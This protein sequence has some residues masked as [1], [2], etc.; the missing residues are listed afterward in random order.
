M[1]TTHFSASTRR[2]CG[3]TDNAFFHY[4]SSK[5]RQD[6]ERYARYSLCSDCSRLLR[7]A[8]ASAPAE[9]HAAD[10]GLPDLWGGSAK[11]QAWADR[12]RRSRQQLVSG[13]RIRAAAT[14]EPLLELARLTLD[15]MFRIQDPGF[16]IASEKAGFH[17]DSLKVDV[18]LLLK[19]RLSPLDRTMAGSVIGYWLQA[20]W[21]AVS[22]IARDVSDRIKPRMAGDQAE[23]TA[24]FMQTA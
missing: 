6:E 1:T 16:W 4:H 3:H 13:F 12:I 17:V 20:D 14:Q 2:V 11:Q 22:S 5:A 23:E 21:S 7:S 24:A 10:P 9:K 19:G 18:E 15:L 8:W